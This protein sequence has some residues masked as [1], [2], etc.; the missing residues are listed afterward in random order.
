MDKLIDYICDEM[1]ELE[2]KADKGKLSMAEV[3][4]ADML[5]HLKKNILTSEA[6]M[7]EGEYSNDTGNSYARG[8]GRGSN[9]KRDSMG[10]YSSRMYSG[11]SYDDGSYEGSYE[12]GGNRGGYSRD[13]MS[14]LRD[15]EDNAQDEESRRMIKNWMKQLGDR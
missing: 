11:R 9:A 6:M 1:E 13:M 3:Q 8:R 10:R 15:M 7:D 12:R 14:M 4:Y 5:A 2:R